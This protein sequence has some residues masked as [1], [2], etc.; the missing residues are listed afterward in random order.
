MNGEGISLASLK[1]TDIDRALAAKS[2]GGSC[3]RITINCYAKR[4]RI[5][6]RYAE[7]RG[8]CV[9]GIAAAIMP[10]RVYLDETVPTGLA[11]QDVQ[12]LLATTEGEKPTD[13]RDR[14]ILL[15]FAVYGLR[16]GE[17]GGLQL[18]DIDWVAETLR[19]RRPKPGRTHLY[20][21][22]RSVGQAI[23]CYLRD[24]RPQRTE[25]TVFFTHIAPIRPLSSGAL[26]AIFRRR[27]RCLDIVSRH[28]GPHMLRHAC[29]QHL[30]NQGLSM[31]QIGDHLGHRS[32]S[33][34]AVYAKIDL[35]RLREVADF[36]LEGL[37]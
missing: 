26:G 8:W 5:F 17:V 7:Q 16:S 21:L 23:L 12:R 14:A 3:S 4:L 34:T 2:A 30:L 35:A 6:L 20:P 28:R 9:P 10:P 22:S 36:D 11:W 32:L 1:I 29:A 18:D 27:L 37:A 15:L 24:V 13:K 25:R 19:V 33:S 31:K